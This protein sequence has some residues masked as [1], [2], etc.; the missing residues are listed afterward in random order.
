[1]ANQHNNSNNDNNNMTI[2]TIASS[3]SSSSSSSTTAPPSPTISST[4][5][6]SGVSQP[7]NH[8]LS[9]AVGIKHLHQIS[10]SSSSSSSSSRAITQ[11]QSEETNDEDFFA[12]PSEPH[13]IPT[14]ILLSIDQ[15]EYLTNSIASLQML[16]DQIPNQKRLISNFRDRLELDKREMLKRETERKKRE[17]DMEAIQSSFSFTG[18]AARIRGDI[19]ERTNAVQRDLTL[20][21]KAEA[22]IR[23]QVNETS[24]KLMDAIEE[25]T[26]MDEKHEELTS[27][28]K[29]LMILLDQT[30]E[31]DKEDQAIKIQINSVKGN[32]VATVD[33]RDRHLAAEAE[34][35]SSLKMIQSALLVLKLVLEKEA[36]VPD[37]FR[38]KLIY[39]AKQYTLRADLY[40]QNAFAIDPSIPEHEPIPDIVHE[41]RTVAAIGRCE[42]KLTRVKTSLW[43]LHSAS[44][45]LL[46]RVDSLRT[47]IRATRAKLVRRRV[48]IMECALEIVR[49]GIGSNNSNGN[50]GS[51]SNGYSSNGNGG[52]G[53]SSQGYVNSLSGL[54]SG[55][56]R[57]PGRGVPGWTLNASVVQS[58]QGSSSNLY[59][60]GDSNSN[61]S[62]STSYQDDGGFFSVD[63]QIRLGIDALGLL[64]VEGYG[65]DATKNRIRRVNNPDGDPVVEGLERESLDEDDVLRDPWSLEGRPI[66]PPVRFISSIPVA[67]RDELPVYEP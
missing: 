17:A 48:A 67:S 53:N 11:T 38:A 23:G 54:G 6:Q 46:P 58:G 30:F 29:Q 34:M 62:N 20:A 5:P 42:T 57:S 39:D 31:D 47:E 66:P 59:N 15:Y 37:W 63:S 19:D 16:D 7:H 45:A 50:N 18:I 44:A 40:I 33:E 1:M 24:K 60:N 2:P 27:W 12:P 35:K 64:P 32:F 43:Y 41:N 8:F 4:S 13:P 65:W 22:K 14:N 3:S 28:R 36:E 25:I 21:R 49:F 9:T 56:S 55:S 10:N 51:Y 52:G 61:N 26:K